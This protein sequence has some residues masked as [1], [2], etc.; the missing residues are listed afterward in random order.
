MSVRLAVSGLVTATGG[1]LLVPA[2]VSAATH[3]T[4]VA[5][6]SRAVRPGDAF[7][8]LRGPRTDGHRFVTDAMTR[9]AALAVISDADAAAGPALVVA[10]T[11][12]ALG[13][14]AGLHRRTL[15][16]DVVGITGSVGKTTTVGLC[17]QVL[18]QR[19]VT[20]RSAESWNAEIGVALT[21]LGLQPSHQVAVL[22]MAM[23]GTGQ[24]TELVGMALPRI[25]AVTNIADVHLE[26]LGSR[27]RIAA[28]K[29]ELLSGLPTDGVAIVNA[30]DPFAPRLVRDV[31]CRVVQFGTWA[32]ADVRATEITS[33]AA[34]CRF[35][36]HL[37]SDCAE[38]AMPVVGAHHVL[39]ALVAA[40]VG[41]VLGESL[42]EIVGGLA[43]ARVAKM[44]QEISTLENDVLLIDDSYNA[45][46]R[47]MEAAFDVLRQVGG[48]RRRVLILGEMLELGVESAVFHRQAGE[49][50]AALAPAAMLVV[51]PN[52]RWYLEGATR[53]SQAVVA[54]AWARTP[55]EAIPLVRDIVRP[56][57]VVLVKGSRGI[58]MEHVVAALRG[59]AV[60]TPR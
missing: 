13:Q 33:S 12:R 27:E 8:A 14:I 58:E 21:L 46:P 43:K 48:T 9:G 34:G 49:Q 56:G 55:H 10:D 50:A 23:R 30:D 35:V 3:I 32:D 52:A 1:R 53:G 45:G 39:N 4:G 6:D 22:E 15:S 31:R 60:G 19:F 51:G 24:L 16:L 18:A 47:S 29:A 54:T 40:S 28:A 37:G 11:L 26:T 36:L 25:G 59:R 5:T 20:A 2:G 7:V 42:A 41:W 17:A 38:A 44:R 57:D